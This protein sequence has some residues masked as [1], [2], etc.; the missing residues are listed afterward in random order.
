MTVALEQSA[1]GTKP[2]FLLFP[3][4]HRTAAK[5]IDLSDR[6]QLLDKN[7]GLL[8][9][10]NK[11]YTLLAIDGTWKMAK[12][13][14]TA[15]LPFVLEAGGVPINF[16]IGAGREGG[17]EKGE[18]DD[19][20]AFM[21]EPGKGCMTTLQAVAKAVGIL[22]GEE[23]GKGGEAEE[24]ALRPLKLLGDFQAKWDPALQL[25]LSGQG[26]MYYNRKCKKI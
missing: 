12:E 15:L 3:F 4:S 25:R 19:P 22:Q 20:F 9:R 6:Q 18:G 17:E 1:A 13:M 21:M 7:T 10:Y 14:A 5:I 8:S 26:A 2:L 23:G 11:P 16:D 24:V